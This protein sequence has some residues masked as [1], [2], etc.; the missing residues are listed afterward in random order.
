M[1]FVAAT[2][3]TPA[4]EVQKEMYSVQVPELRP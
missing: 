4:S 3:V 1:A 2:F